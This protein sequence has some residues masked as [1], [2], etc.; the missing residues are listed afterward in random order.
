MDKIRQ[1][2]SRFR[3]ES[4]A[5]LLRQEGLTPNGFAKR[6]GVAHS[7]VGAWMSGVVT[8]QLGT[9]LR[10]CDEFG[11]S[12]QFFVSSDDDDSRPD[13]AGC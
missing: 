2:P 3:R 10:L 12:L 8:P 9:L 6:V 11:V 1:A 5:D 4:I 13:G 7:A